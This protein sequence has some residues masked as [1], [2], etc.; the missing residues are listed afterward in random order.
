M[1]SPVLWGPN[2]TANN[3]QN[4]E[5]L[6][7][8]NLIAW[9]GPK[10]YI[11][12]NNFE[13]NATTGWSLGTTG[14]LTNGIPTGTPTFG[15][16]TTS[17][18]ISAVNTNVLAG[19]YSLS[20][21]ASAA[22]TVGNMLA[23]DP[24]VIDSEGQAKVLTYK[25]YYS[26]PSGATTGNFSGTS[27]NSFGVA[28]WDATNNVYLP[29]VGNFSMTQ[30]SGSG[31]ATGTVQTGLTTASIRFIVYNANATSG[32]ITVNFDDFYLG[33]Q[34]API[35]PVITDWALDTGFTPTNYG[36]IS[37]PTFYSRR[38]G[39]TKEVYGYFTSGTPSTTLPGYI[40]LSQ[41]INTAKYGTTASS[42]KIGQF[43][44][45]E[46]TTQLLYS[47]NNAGDIFYDG[48]DATK[49]FLCTQVNTP[50]Y[51]KS[52]ANQGA[53]SGNNT[54]VVFSYPLA[55]ASSQV[56]M[57]NDTD[58][59]I[60]VAKASGLPASVTSGNII[61]LPSV[62]YD[63]SASYSTSTGRYTV[64]VTG[65]YRVS[66]S[67]IGGTASI[68]YFIYKNGSKDSCLGVSDTVV[69]VTAGSSVVSCIAGDLLDVRPGGTSGSSSATNVPTVTFERLSGPAVI[70]AT[71]S[72]N[73]RYFSS[74]TTVSGS[75]ATV[76]YSTKGWDTHNAY[77]ASTGI[78]TAPVSGKYQV[79]ASIAMTGTFILN[80]IL[81]LQVQQTGS[82]T[83]TSESKAFSGGAV[84]QM[85]TNVG[86]IFYMLAGDQLKVQ[87]SNS[88]TTP[89]IA[90]T[91]TQ[92]W[93]SL[94]RVGN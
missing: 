54:T 94:S 50:L 25:F 83:Q 12:Y 4:Q 72:V 28:A 75:L 55:G 32:A 46:G 35:G 24:L 77:N 79:N 57:S 61:I 31:I 7:N 91:T 88:G 13:N 9:N 17:L 51:V 53:T 15:S 10:N 87:V 65:Y 37:N 86:D 39:D 52:A 19:N 93:I 20:Y 56:Q 30:N 90:A 69:G 64:P 14:T 71:E 11:S 89:V 68:E 5:L 85:N 74:S 38:V 22:T 21:V 8:G 81:D 67:G 16:G 62:T 66:A 49:V 44:F 76:M 3:L 40:A 2:S 18:A 45:A 70:A 80:S 42:Q 60:I 58:T 29:L 84:T 23:S 43:A 33:P 92:N 27:S 48:S 1:S 78:Y 47:A 6:A 82:A 41:S 34:T 26:V 36:T 73:M 59:R 63:T